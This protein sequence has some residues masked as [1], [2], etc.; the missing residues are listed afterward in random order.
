MKMASSVTTAKNVHWSRVIH[1]AEDLLESNVEGMPKLQAVLNR[2]IDLDKIAGGSAEMF[3]RGAFPGLGFQAHEGYTIQGQALIDLQRE[4]EEY[5]HGLKRYLRL[6]GIDVKQFRPQ[7]ADPSNH[8]A[9]QIDLIAAALGIPKR[10]LLGSE[11][12]ELASTQDEK[13][14]MELIDARRRDH[15]EATIL[16]PLIDRLILV[17]VLPQ[18]KDGYG[19]EWPE[20][21]TLSD[22]EIAEIAAA[23]TKALKDYVEAIGAEDIVPPEI[24]LRNILGL[25]EEQ[26]DHVE[27]ILKTT[28]RDLGEE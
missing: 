4:I 3:W 6:S 25:T 14:F 22:K 20:L 13:A 9:V 5:M 16:R 27:R 15:C 10:I 7:V 2:L 1:V 19:V 18:P 21:L 17:K 12:G 28:R 8:V 11:R 24:F 23:R 26:M